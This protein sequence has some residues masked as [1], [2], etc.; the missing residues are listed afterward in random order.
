MTHSGPEDYPG[1]P[2]AWN[3]ALGE[4]TD[5]ASP[6]LNGAN[7]YAQHTRYWV[8]PVR[9]I[10]IALLALAVV[11][12]GVYV[13]VSSSKPAKDAGAQVSSVSIAPPPTASDTP[14][15]TG[16][17]VT[18]ANTADAHATQLTQALTAATSWAQLVPFLK[19][20]SS[21]GVSLACLNVTSSNE[22]KCKFGAKP[23]SHHAVL[24]G[25]AAALN[26]LPAIV[27][28][29]GAHGWDV[30][31]LTQANCPLSHVTITINKTED[32]A[33]SDHHSFVTSQINS[34]KP[35]LIFSSDSLI[36]LSYATAPPKPKGKP[37]EKPEDA[38]I[39][40]L[41]SAAEHYDEVGKVVVIGAPPGTKRLADCIAGVPSPKGCV[42]SPGSEWKAYL[43]L[44]RSAVAGH[45]DFIDPTNYF[46]HLDRCPA[47]VGV[48]PVYIDG[49]R[50][51]EA[52]A[53]SLSFVFAPYIATK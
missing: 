46:C 5:P 22:S 29:L 11:G 24:L 52:F 36:D 47:I 43:S 15:S 39:S 18:V 50:V 33:C 41:K 6:S 26:Y 1:G 25:D 49:V 34:I 13:L 16:G 23:A 10:A 28:E 12:L 48:T 2:D 9:N 19:N 30:Q 40:G 53:K 20:V 44:E 37:R 45:A 51:S 31:V 17:A 42:A 35:A 38:F 8:R 27:A 32:S 21:Q 3:A 7:P 4:A 14:G